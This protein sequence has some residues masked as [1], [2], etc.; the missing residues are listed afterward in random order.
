M[1]AI[2]AAWE[3]LAG[4]PDP[5]LPAVSVVD[6]GIVR[7]VRRDGE[8]LVVTI[9]PTYSGCPA[10]VAIERDVRAALEPSWPH[11]E[12]RT[13][14]RPPWTTQWITEQ[15]RRRLADAGIAPPGTAFLPLEPAG[16]PVACPHCGSA[17]VAEISAFG[18]A[19]CRALW[20]CRSCHEPF[21]YVKA[22]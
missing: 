16:R 21:D 14:R 4:V 6:L 13:E 12:V 15:G 11:V 8:R 17:D 7:E 2:E 18:A 10:M 5:E 3:L 22:H 20:R 9:T 1:S 19:P